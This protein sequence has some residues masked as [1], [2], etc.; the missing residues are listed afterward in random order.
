MFLTKMAKMQLRAT[1]PYA[2]TCNTMI[3]AFWRRLLTLTPCFLGKAFY[4]KKR[5]GDHEKPKRVQRMF[6]PKGPRC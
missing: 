4:L 6:L 2:Y 1:F 5:S 3:G